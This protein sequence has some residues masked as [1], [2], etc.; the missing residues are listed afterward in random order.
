MP[1]DGWISVENVRNLI[2]ERGYKYRGAAKSL[3]THL[4]RHPQT[5]HAINLPNRDQMAVAE[6]R[7]ILRYAGMTD[8][9][10]ERFVGNCRS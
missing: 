3:R 8:E 1:A 7:I 2:R 9:E 4:W 6:V 10:I 5:L